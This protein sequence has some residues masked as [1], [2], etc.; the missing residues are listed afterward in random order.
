MQL[1][2]EMARARLLASDARVLYRQ[3]EGC[4]QLLG[5]GLLRVSPGGTFAL[6]MW[7]FKNNS[8]VFP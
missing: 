4:G 1:D 2:V 3:R 5:E 7:G 8:A 6:S